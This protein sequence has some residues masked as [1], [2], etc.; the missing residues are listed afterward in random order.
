[1]VWQLLS[2][3]TL[4][5][6]SS[7]SKPHV[8]KYITAQKVEFPRIKCDSEIPVTNSEP[9]YEEGGGRKVAHV[10]KEEKC[11]KARHNSHK[12]LREKNG[13]QR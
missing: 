11:W 7:N 13:G 10:C 4:N 5:R 1:M 12:V 2:I 9:G 8:R 3:F 6:E